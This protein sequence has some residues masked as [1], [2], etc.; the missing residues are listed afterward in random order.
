MTMRQM[1]FRPT[2]SGYST[3]AMPITAMVAASS[4]TGLAPTQIAGSGVPGVMVTNPS[5]QAIY[6]AIGSSSIAAAASTTSLPS[7]GLCL[8]PGVS[9]SIT[10][11][12][13]PNLRWL[14]AVTSGGVAAPGLF[15]TPGLGQ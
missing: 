9:K 14:S 8:N 11:P 7:A 5:T 3:G 2:L 15:V 13:N 12:G 10:I 1:I 4:S 6:I